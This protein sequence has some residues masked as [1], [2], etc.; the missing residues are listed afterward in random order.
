MYAPVIDYSTVQLLISLAFGNNRAMFQYK[1][2]SRRGDLSNFLN[3]FLQI[4]FQVTKE[5]PF[6]D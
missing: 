5:E 6:Q 2:Q 4:Y 1:R 3:P